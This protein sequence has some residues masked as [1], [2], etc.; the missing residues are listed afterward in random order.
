[1]LRNSPEDEEVVIREGAG[2]TV[3]TVNGGRWPGLGSSP[4]RPGLNWVRVRHPAGSPVAVTVPRARKRLSGRAPLDEQAWR[5]VEGY[6]RLRDVLYTH[7]TPDATE[8]A[9]RMVVES[10]PDPDHP[11]RRVGDSW[12]DLAPAMR[13]LYGSAEGV[14][15][16][17]LQGQVPV[18]QP[19]V[20]RLRKAYLEGVQSV[21]ARWP[22]RWYLWLGLAWQLR[23]ADQ[24]DAAMAAFIRALELWPEGP[25]P[26]LELAR[27]EF[28]LWQE[29]NEALLRHRPE[30]LMSDS[31]LHFEIAE[32]FMK[33]RKNL[34]IDATL[35]D[36]R[37][38]IR[39]LRTRK[40]SRSSPR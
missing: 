30:E 17:V 3:L 34:G 21:L 11:L 15:T 10:M 14:L 36:I 1:V 35:K 22:D 13:A 9:R 8:R 19:E 23:W 28:L 18:K 37:D 6:E 38:R 20:L 29:G 32:G 31:L 26:W 33:K 25:W 39:M 12:I 5:E 16:S 24:P 27:W 40:R 4:A 2:Q 7:W